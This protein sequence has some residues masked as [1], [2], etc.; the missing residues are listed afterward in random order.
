[1]ENEQALNIGLTR[2]AAS[3]APDG[4]AYDYV[5]HADEVGEW[6]GLLT[7]E[8]IE[9]GELIRSDASD[10]DSNADAYSLWCPGSGTVISAADA[11]AE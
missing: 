8:V 2:L 3:V 10:D 1:M 5:Y 4:S 7:S 11:G 6:Y 9:L